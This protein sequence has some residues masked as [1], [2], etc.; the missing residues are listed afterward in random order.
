MLKTK[1]TQYGF[2]AGVLHALEIMGYETL[3]DVQEQVLPYAFAGSD[4]IVQAQT[5]SGKTAAFAIPLCENIILEQRHPQVLVLTPTR[6]LAVQV[7]ADIANIGRFSHIRVAAIYGQQP[8][9]M[10]KSQLRQ[11]VHIIVATP[12]RIMDHLQRGNV[13][14]EAIKYLVLDEADEMLNMGFIEQVEAILEVLP[15]NR[16]TMLFS[17]TMPDAILK[18]CHQYMRTPKR[19]QV[20]SKNPTTARIEQYYYAVEEEGKFALLSQIMYTQR[21][22][23]CIIFCHTREKVDLLWRR[24]KAKGCSCSALHGGMDQTDRLAAMQSFKNWEFPLLIATDVAGR[25]IDVEELGLVINYDIPS[26]KEKYVHRIG[27]TGR[28]D[29]TGVAIT[30]VSAS[31]NEMLHEIEDYIGYQIPQKALPSPEEIIDGRARFATENAARP[32]P[33]RNRRAELNS[34]IMKIRINAGKNK[35]LRPGDILGALT[36]IE[37]LS[38]NDIGIIDVQDYFSYV[39]I[40]ANK[41]SLV[42]EA[43]QDMPI[44]GKKVNVKQMDF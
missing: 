32:M 26:E 41:G 12:G 38:V 11:R 1:F 5:G 23:R 35:K 36:N 14:F 40:F 9:Y 39:D 43:L 25:G 28:I 8:I 18:I 24:M 22:E 17:A 2:S 33:T 27:R 13:S 10:Q 15:A 6:E 34:D 16:V 31:E 7:Q 4:L 21:P 44:K 29:N 20:L 3:T 19:I 42:L 30:F 37:C